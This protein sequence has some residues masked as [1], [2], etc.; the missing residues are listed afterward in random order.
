LASFEDVEEE[1]IVLSRDFGFVRRS[2][3]SS[4]LGEDVGM[5]LR[6]RLFAGGAMP[7]EAGMNVYYIGR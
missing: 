6:F 2:S 3:F 4:S 5:T 7:A 1:L